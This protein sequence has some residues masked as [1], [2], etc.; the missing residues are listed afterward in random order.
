MEVLESLCK[1]RY[2]SVSQVQTLHFTSRQTA[3]R[4]LRALTQ[5]R[6]VEPFNVPAVPERLF[7]L[8]RRGAKTLAAHTGKALDEL[9]W[10]QHGHQPKDYYFVRHFIALNDFQ[11]TLTQACESSGINLL[12]FIPEYEGEK[13]PHGGLRSFIRDEVVEVTKNG[14]KLAHTPDAVFGT[15]KGGRAGLFFVEIDRAT[16]VVSDPSKGFLKAVRF[17]LNYFETGGYRRYDKELNA[18]MPFT[19]GF[20]LL[21]VTSAEARIRTM[22][23]ATTAL[24][25]PNPIAKQFLWVT[26]ADQVTAETVL[27]PIW[28]SLDLSDELTYRFG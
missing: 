9:P 3:Y 21:V 7:Y 27:G 6:Y 23:E 11:I 15:E 18:P 20:R 16:V 26:T 12:G 19:K 4:R 10:R 17:Y 13:T 22:R 28:R 2:L 5:F 24:D 8:S 1:Y 14:T 25:F